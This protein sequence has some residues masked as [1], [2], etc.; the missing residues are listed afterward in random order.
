MVKALVKTREGHGNLE[1][2]DKEVATP[3]DDKVKIKVHYAGI[4]GTDIHTYEGHYKVNFPVTLG[5]EF[6]G[7]I[8][9]V[10]ADV[11]DFKVG[12][13]VTSET[14]FYV[15][16]ECEYCKSKTIIYA[17]IEKV[18]E[19]KLMAHLLIMSLHVKKVCIIFQ[20]KYRISLQL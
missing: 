1:L 16:N 14:T 20:T 2:L 17:T 5:H 8:V 18:L 9:E 11:K 3:L 7:E 19:H 10:G 12:D 13:R 4:C 15:C 6:S